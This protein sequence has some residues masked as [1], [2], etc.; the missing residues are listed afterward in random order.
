MDLINVW[1]LVNT[2]TF[3]IFSNTNGECVTYGGQNYRIISHLSKVC[4]G[5]CL[6]RNNQM[7]FQNQAGLQLIERKKCV[8]LL[9][10]KTKEK[11]MKELRR[12]N[13]RAIIMSVY[14]CG[15]V[16]KPLSA[17]ATHSFLLNREYYT[18]DY[19]GRRRIVSHLIK[20]TQTQWLFAS[21]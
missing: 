13:V 18:A 15:S 11:C 14:V 2:L 8:L 1:M 7:S 3:S 10:I 12:D 21:K 6:V 17:I 5:E 19:D 20:S 4:H 16:G 9:A